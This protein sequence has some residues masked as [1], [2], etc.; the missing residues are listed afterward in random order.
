MDSTVTNHFSVLVQGDENV[1][2]LKAILGKVDRLTVGRIKAGPQPDADVA[3]AGAVC[4]ETHYS[5][6]ELDDGITDI[7]VMEQ[8]DGCLMFPFRLPLIGNVN[9]EDNAFP[10]AG[11]HFY[12]KDDF[13]GA[14][15]PVMEG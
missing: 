9:H 14:T 6:Q 10:G 7:D 12:V 8:F 1:F 3:A 13:F 4:K 11:N 5:F 2:S 15:L